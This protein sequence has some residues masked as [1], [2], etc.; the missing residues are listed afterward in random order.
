MRESPLSSEV[1][2]VRPYPRATTSRPL[3]LSS[4]RDA[5]HGLHVRRAARAL[6]PAQDGSRI[7]SVRRYLGSTWCGARDQSLCVPVGA[8]GASG[9]LHTDARVFVQCQRWRNTD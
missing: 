3:R 1:S 2:H 5:V 8:L 9:A 7:E 6:T 4:P